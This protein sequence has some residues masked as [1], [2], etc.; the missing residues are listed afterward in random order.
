MHPLDIDQTGEGRTAVTVPLPLL[1][2]RCDAHA[3]QEDKRGTVFRLFVEVGGEPGSFDLVATPELRGT[4]LGWVA[5][6][7]GFGAG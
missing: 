3:V 2:A 7:C 5:D 4:L 6:W 1:P